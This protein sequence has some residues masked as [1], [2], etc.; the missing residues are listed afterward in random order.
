MNK[1]VDMGA[2]TYQG[3]L[4][5]SLL[6]LVLVSFDFIFQLGMGEECTDL[7]FSP[8]SNLVCLLYI[9]AFCFFLCVHKTSQ[10]EPHKY[11]FCGLRYFKG[12][13]HHI[14]YKATQRLASKEEK[15]WVVVCGRRG[16]RLFSS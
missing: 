13:K 5:G 3:L 7:D 16:C 11:N 12:S 8:K 2:L 1:F 14:T 10:T 4:W 15:E 6:L 9:H